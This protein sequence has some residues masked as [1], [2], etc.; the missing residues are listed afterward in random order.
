MGTLERRHKGK[1]IITVNVIRKVAMA[2]NFERAHK[3]YPVPP[4][5]IRN[6]DAHLEL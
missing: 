1:E 3:V 6:S 5:R 2:E 4:R